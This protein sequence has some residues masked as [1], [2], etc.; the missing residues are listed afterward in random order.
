M[1]NAIKRNEA[2]GTCQRFLVVLFN[3]IECFREW[4]VRSVREFGNLSPKFASAFWAQKN[5]PQNNTKDFFLEFCVIS[6]LVLLGCGSV[7]LC[8]D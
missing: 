3:C 5:D 4:K 8:L 7:A 1:P 6:W 2:I